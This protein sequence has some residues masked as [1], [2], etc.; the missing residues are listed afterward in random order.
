[1]QAEPLEPRRIRHPRGAYGWVDLRI[2][3]EG[4]LRGLGPEAALVYL[5]L[6][7][8]GNRAG[9]SFWGRPRIAQMLHLTPAEIDNA[10][11]R[12]IAADLIAATDRIV[13]VLPVPDGC[14]RRV[15]V[16]HHAT[17]CGEARGAT[18]AKTPRVTHVQEPVPRAIS[19]DEIRAHEGEA[20]AR[21]AR[22]YGVKAPSATAVW[23]LARS[24]ALE[25]RR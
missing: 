22:F 1:M 24:I 4:H 16:D 14:H 13:Q 10:L 7:T 2:V 20:R 9:L 8:V 17:G 18:G 5:F 12:L 15:I 6:C 11:A 21:I 3:T 23:A 19:D 25:G